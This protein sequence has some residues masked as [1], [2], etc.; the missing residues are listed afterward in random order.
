MLADPFDAFVNV[1]AVRRECHHK[2][3]QNAAPIQRR[4][5]YNMT[6]ASSDLLRSTREG[7]FDLRH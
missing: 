3:T 1:R 7:V 2:S 4:R 5:S 6:I